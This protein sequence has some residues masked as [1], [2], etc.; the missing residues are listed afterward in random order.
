M[1]AQPEVDV[2]LPGGGDADL[3]IAHCGVGG[4]FESSW[5]HVKGT[6]HAPGPQLMQWGGVHPPNH[7]NP[8]NPAHL[9]HQRDIRV[10]H[11]TGRHI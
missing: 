1:G 7:I 11:S 5:H 8:T 4:E 6:H 10:V 3:H 9:Q 2:L